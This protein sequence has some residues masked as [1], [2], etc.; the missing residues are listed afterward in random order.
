MPRSCTSAAIR[1]II[2]A[3][4][5]AVELTGRLVGDQHARPWRR[6]RAR[7][8]RAAAGRRRARSG[9][10]SACSAEP[11]DPRAPRRPA[12]R[13]RPAG[14]ADPQRHL[15]VLGGRQHRAEPEGLEDV[16]ELARGAVGEPSSSRRRVPVARRADPARGRAVE[17][18][19]QV[20]Q[21]RLARARAAAQHD[22][23]ARLH[24]ERRRRR[25]HVT[26]GL[27]R[28]P[29]RRAVGPR[30]GSRTCGRG[31]AGFARSRRCSAVRDSSG[32]PVGRCCIRRRR[33]GHTPRG[34]ARARAAPGRA[35]RAR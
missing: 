2:A 16:A 14:R 26:A 8:R 28:W 4:V 22:Q 32:V 34:R 35:A 30:V 10:C 18:A 27:A 20:Q 23:L 33:A 9:R 19:E 6:A 15:D 12:R 17:A 25:V 29:G 3:A 21:R 13:A 31:I 11:D 1:S 7:C 24:L 5:R